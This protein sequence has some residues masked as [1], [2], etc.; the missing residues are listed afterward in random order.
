M[1][2][3]NIFL[4]DRLAIFES[5]F[6]I[7]LFWIV[8]F[9]LLRLSFVLFNYSIISVK[10][11]AFSELFKITW[12]ALPLDISL[13]GYFS[14]FT[15][16]MLSIQNF[17]NLSIFDKI[18]KYY[19]YLLIFLVS[20][21]YIG[22]I[23]IYSEW[24]TKLN[25][26]ALEYLKNPAEVISS[27]KTSN[28]II[29]FIILVIL[30][31]IGIY[32]YNKLF[33]KTIKEIKT[34]II[35]KIA[36]TLITP[37]FIFI[38][39]RGGISEIP[40]SQS[41]SYFSKHA[42]VNDISVNSVWN[43]IFDIVHSQQINDENIFEVLPKPKAEQTVLELHKLEKDTTIS[44]IREGIKPNI[45]I[46]LLES[47]SADLVQS[48][49][50]IEGITPNFRKLEKEGLLFTHLYSSG[51]RSQQGIA[52]I[53]GGFPALPI[54]TLTT[55]PEKFRNTPTLTDKFNKNGYYTS[56]FYGGNLRY[57]N[58]KAYLFHN[59]F[60]IIKEEKDYDNSNFDHGKLGYHDKPILLNFVDEINK[61]KQPFFANI[62]TL[63][64]HSPYDMQV[65]TTINFHDSEND[66]LNSAHY[67]DQALA[68]FFENAKKQN[69]YK[70]TL[71]I[72]VADHSHNTYR[73]W[74]ISQKE[75]RHIP[76]MFLGGAL[77]E[78]YKG[79]TY[80]KICSQTDLTKTIL[81]Q[82][83]IDAT[84]FKWS[85]DLFNPYTPQFAYF[86]LNQGFG[87]IRDDGYLSYD[88][89]NKRFLHKTYTDS[90]LL[91]QRLIEG[92]S[93]LQVLFQEYIDY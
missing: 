91:Q 69:W 48:L 3:S 79:K 53:W 32:L 50:G 45:V 64:S 56:F 51:N 61:Q 66:F 49:G 65:D 27:N 55:K 58:I 25:S 71:F 78:E 30:I 57:G 18:I 20:F 88:K 73:H 68:L 28:T 13:I 2:L 24:K 14:A 22:E 21:V 9:F 12:Y 29:L 54:T 52:S 80:D 47:W 70:N 35:Y 4:R 83:K 81:K 67:T 93:Y 60:D 23:G 34:K 26:K 92:E 15:W 33:H 31:F 84:D 1:N 86:E 44:I 72:L 10:E 40:I 6:R 85:K 19:N 76:M 36:F 17:V 11:V 38:G 77:K 43:L 5:F 8:F 90:L 59:G 42:I 75:Y 46:I 16:L 7:V 74:E 37:A 87:W 41:Q 89:F 82:L 62:F 63:S 39:I